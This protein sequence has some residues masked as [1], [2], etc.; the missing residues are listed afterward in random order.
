MQVAISTSKLTARNAKTR[1]VVQ[2]T[3][4]H[5]FGLKMYENRSKV[6]PIAKRF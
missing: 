4:V 5:S 2:V 6:S 3:K 1:F